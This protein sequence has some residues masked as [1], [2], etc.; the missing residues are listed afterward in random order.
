MLTRLSVA[1]RTASARACPRTFLFEAVAA[2]RNPAKSPA[3]SD[4][5]TASQ[6]PEGTSSAGQPPSAMRSSSGELAR[7]L[8]QYA[9]EPQALFAAASIST[10][11]T[12]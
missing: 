12:L 7:S 6:W 8:T 11:S 2:A 10:F 3:S 1:M 5:H 4:R 9:K